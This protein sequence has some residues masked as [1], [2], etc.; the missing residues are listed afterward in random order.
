MTRLRIR[1]KAPPSP[2]R[3]P[4]DPRFP[5]VNGLITS[6]PDVE[7]HAIDDEG[8]EVALDGVTSFHVHAAQGTEPVRAVLSFV[9]VDVDVEIAESALARRF[10]DANGR[11]TL[12]PLALVDDRSHAERVADGD[13][14][15]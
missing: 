4:R 1:A 6:W 5:I 7:V 11:A 3:D 13:A 2:P 12:E 8:R 10:V 14:E 9:E 15:P